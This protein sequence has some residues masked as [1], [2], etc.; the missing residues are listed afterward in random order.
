MTTPKE[1]LER[2]I[3]IYERNAGRQNEKLAD[4]PLVARRALASLEGEAVERVARIIDPSAWRDKGYKHAE[5][6]IQQSLIKARA[7][8]AT[9]LVPNEA[10][11]RAE[12]SDARQEAADSLRVLDAIA[13]YVGCPHDEELTVDHVRQHYMKLENAAQRQGVE[14][15]GRIA[16]AQAYSA[17]RE[18]AVR[19]DEREKCAKDKALSPD[20]VEWIV[21]DIAELGVKI[22]NQ[23]FFLYKGS[24][25]VYGTDDISSAGGFA[26]N[27]DTT[28]P[29]IHKWR[30]VFKREFGECCHPV[31]RV[32]PTRIG[33]V[34]LDDSDDWKPLPAAI[35]S[36]G[37]K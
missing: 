24:S 32:D 29:A 8:L 33:T 9:G 23:F 11:I 26:L 20:E 19:A 27:E 18:A 21:N 5:W 16:N 2:I 12:L 3:Q 30:H 35:R 7:I 13:E 34:S 6:R 4:I 25:L 37:A 22:G 36:G 17:E 31:N 14:D 10:A 1:A 28:P 15:A